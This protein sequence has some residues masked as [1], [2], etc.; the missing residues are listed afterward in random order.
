VGFVIWR[1][2]FAAF[3]PFTVIPI[4]WWD[5]RISV[6][7]NGG[8]PMIR[9]PKWT[10]AVLVLTFIL[11]LTAP[12][13]ADESKGTIKSVTADKNQ[14]VCTDA[15]GKDFTFH[16]AA[17]GKVLIDDKESTLSDLK[18]GDEATVTWEKKNGKMEASEVR[19]KRI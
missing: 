2:R 10:L 16:L 9:L 1:Q 13:L 7:F 19:V 12:V 5:E 15:A 8:L 3:F 17:K 11:G 18:K 4:S 14:F 6:V